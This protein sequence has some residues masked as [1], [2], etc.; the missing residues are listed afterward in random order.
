MRENSMSNSD[1]ET[2][3]VECASRALLYGAEM[4]SLHKLAVLCKGEFQCDARLSLLDPL[5]H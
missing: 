4:F 2:F 1:L 5:S 3:Y